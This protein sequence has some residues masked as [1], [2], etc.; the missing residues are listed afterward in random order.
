M[1]LLQDLDASDA[2]KLTVAT[3]L[4]HLAAQGRPRKFGQQLG[5]LFAY[6]NGRG[7]AAKLH[8][9]LIPDGPSGLV[10][11]RRRMSLFAA[12]TTFAEQLRRAWVRTAVD[13]AGG[14]VLWSLNSERG[15]VPYVVDGPLGAAFAVVLNE[16]RRASGPRGS[17]RVRR[18]QSETFVTGR[19]GS[20]DELAAVDGYQAKLPTADTGRVIVPIGDLD[21]ADPGLREIRR[22]RTRVWTRSS[23]T[24][25][26]S[27]S[28][29]RN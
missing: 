24:M 6:P 17:L 27:S 4:L 16:I 18:L 14:A 3:C 12:D 23:W 13:T 25:P 7:A 26:G 28:G 21:T 8:A 19:I 22:V 9:E 20:R 10:P 11:D 29:A 1:D 15:P 2:V 5:V